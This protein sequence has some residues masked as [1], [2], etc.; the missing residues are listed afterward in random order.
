MD[1]AKP[2]PSLAQRRILWWMAATGE[3]PYWISGRASWEG[4]P[5]SRGCPHGLGRPHLPRLSVEAMLNA[6]M[7]Q[8]ESES[9]PSHVIQLQNLRLDDLRAIPLGR[10]TAAWPAGPR[11]LLTELGREMAPEQP[12]YPWRPNTGG[13]GD[14]TFSEEERQSKVAAYA[15]VQRAPIR[16]LK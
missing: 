10:R 6:A 2:H 4:G 3:R 7:V 12:P 13:T 9:F 16:A 8:V 5:D 1:A 15:G 11:L 14:I